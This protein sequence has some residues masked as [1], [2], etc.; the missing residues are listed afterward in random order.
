VY[1]RRGFDKKPLGLAAG[2]QRGGAKVASV[3]RHG[4]R[5]GARGATWRAADAA[6]RAESPVP[7]SREPGAGSRGSGYTTLLV[8]GR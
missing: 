2:W 3:G 1:S 5:G 6:A 8:M 4:A 7:G